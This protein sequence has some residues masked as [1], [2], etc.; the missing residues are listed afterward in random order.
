MRALYELLKKNARKANALSKFV[1][2]DAFGPNTPIK[3]D[4][5]SPVIDLTNE[6]SVGVFDPVRKSTSATSR[7]EQKFS[8]S[9]RRIIQVCSLRKRKYTIFLHKKMQKQGKKQ[10]QAKTPDLQLRFRG[11]TRALP[12]PLIGR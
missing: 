2:P 4:I 8:I 1:F 5:W 6:S 12:G 7:K 9:M 11:D 10:I 3:T